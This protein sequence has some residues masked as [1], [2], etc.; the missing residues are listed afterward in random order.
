MKHLRMYP[1]NKH[2]HRCELVYAVHHN[3]DVP[4]TLTKKMDRFFRQR[5]NQVS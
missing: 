4:R 5:E 1:N 2:T 3:P